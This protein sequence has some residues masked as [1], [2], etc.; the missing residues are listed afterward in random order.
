MIGI[1]TP[2]NVNNYGTKLQ[3]YAVNKKLL[4]FGF[5][6][7]IINYIPKRDLRINIILRKLFLPKKIMYRV[8][9]HRKK[10][11][12]K[13]HGVYEKVTLRNNAINSL[14]NVCYCLGKR[15]CG[16]ENLVIQSRSYDAIVCG[17]DQ[18]WNPAAIESG[19]N[20]VEFAKG[21]PKIAFS[22]SFG[23]STI[24]DKLIPRYRKFIGDFRWL[25]CREKSGIDIIKSITGRDAEL[26]ADPTLTLARKDWE[27]YC[28]YSTIEIPK[29]K[30]IFCYF[31]GNNSDHRRA[32]VKLREITDCKVVTMPHFKGYVK[33]DAFFADVCLYDVNPAD[34]VKLIANAEYVCTDSF[35]GVVFSNIFEKEYFVFE[36]YKNTDQESTNSRIYSLLS[37]LG[38]KERLVDSSLMIQSISE[39]T[40]D[41]SSVRKRL[42]LLRNSTDEYL[43]NALREI[44]RS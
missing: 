16:Y 4:K 10:T 32:V 43:T 11:E 5:D 40:I 26:T 28:E 30:Y 24:P 27:E 23:V 7:E 1:V 36:R 33:E 44:K 2:L 39:S 17:S 38:T 20:T 29:G 6:S 12:L 41:F 31:L 19:Y 37:V 18:V 13:K 42:A 9:A 35:H 8:N 34:F 21:I 14:D 25:S 22:P 15:I 3:A